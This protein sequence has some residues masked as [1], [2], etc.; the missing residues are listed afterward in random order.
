MLIYLTILLRLRKIRTVQNFSSQVYYR[1]WMHILINLYRSNVNNNTIIANTEYYNT[2]I[3]RG[4]HGRIIVHI[5]CLYWIL[6]IYSSPK[7]VFLNPLK[8][9]SFRISVTSNTSSHIY[10]YYNNIYLSFWCSKVKNPNN[11]FISLTF[12]TILIVYQTLIKYAIIVWARSI[13]QPYAKR[14]HYD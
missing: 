11:S 14:H 6:N 8:S 13:R 7:H 9:I 10:Y 5:R 2:I 1:K 3:I 4:F 12:P